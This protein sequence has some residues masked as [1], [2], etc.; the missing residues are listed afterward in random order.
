[1]ECENLACLLWESKPVENADHILDQQ[2]GNTF[3]QYRRVECRVSLPVP[4]FVHQH[5]IGS[6]EY[7][8]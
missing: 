3:L 2:K 4:K 8:Y 5:Q 1:M 7:T 6:G